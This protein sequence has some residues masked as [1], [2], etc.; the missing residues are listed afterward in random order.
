MAHSAVEEI[1]RIRGPDTCMRRTV[2]SD[3]A[4]EGQKIDEGD[5]VV[6]NCLCAN[7]D[8]A[9]FDNPLKFDVLRDPNPHVGY[10][11]PGPHF[12]LGAHLARREIKVTFREV[13]D[14]VGDVRAA[15]E[16]GPLSS[17]FIHGVRHLP[18]EL[19][20]SKPVGESA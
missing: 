10:G 19:A 11:G 6:T 7:R 4:L 13:F 18:A 2:L 8:E 17:A 14:R 1:V 16:P 20:P 15:G 3:T 5:I 12:C 9:V